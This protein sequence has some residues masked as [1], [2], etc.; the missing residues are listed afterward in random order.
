MPGKDI[1]DDGNLD[2]DMKSGLE[3]TAPLG[4]VTGF[5]LPA[6]RMCA[7]LLVHSSLVHGVQLSEVPSALTTS[8][9]DFLVTLSS[10]VFWLPNLLYKVVFTEASFQ[11]V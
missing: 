7:V 1:A 11:V 6:L 9:L 2:L 8:W 10:P 4:M 3:N 5:L